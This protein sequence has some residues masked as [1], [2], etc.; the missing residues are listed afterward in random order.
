[1][2]ACA[3]VLLTEGDLF[4]V[5]TVMHLMEQYKNTPLENQFRHMMG[6]ISELLPNQVSVDL[7]FGIWH[8]TGN[9]E[10]YE[11]LFD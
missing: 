1:M 10:E 4:T 7:G 5:N 8:N 11:L 2:F 6:K 9:P 3:N